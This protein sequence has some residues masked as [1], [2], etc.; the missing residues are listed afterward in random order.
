MTTQSSVPGADTPAAVTVSRWVNEPCPPWAELL[1][2]HET[3]RLT[4]RHRWTLSALA[5]MGR[6]PK[7]LRSH[8]RTLGWL[9]SDVECWLG[10]DHRRNQYPRGA[11]QTRCSSRKSRRDCLSRVAPF[12]RLLFQDRI[13]KPNMFRLRNAPC[14]STIRTTGRD[15]E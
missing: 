15:L 13:D 11:Q 9:R 8:G 10:R 6:F 3:V 5:L 12:Q 14:A 7:K 4:R 1:T 2:S